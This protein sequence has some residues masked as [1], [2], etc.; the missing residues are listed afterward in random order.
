MKL[1]A[2]EKNIE[3]LPGSSLGQV[4]GNKGDKTNFGA[5]LKNALSE[6]D[7][8]RKDADKHV[9]ELASGKEK[10]IHQTMIALEKAS[11]S[12]KLVMQIRNKIID[13]YKQ[14]ER[15]PV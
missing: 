10:D 13:A 11:V 3:S 8:L 4:P 14:I 6:V 5:T 7:R 9:T 12:F 15:M 1:L 2:F